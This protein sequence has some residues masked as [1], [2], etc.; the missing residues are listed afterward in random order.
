M[1]V[2][3][4]LLVSVRHFYTETVYQY[5]KFEVFTAVTMNGV[6]WDVT[7]CDSC[8]S[9]KNHG[10]TSQKTTFFRYLNRTAVCGNFVQS[11]EVPIILLFL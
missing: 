10:V 7:P 9:Y 5:I 8:G 3:I 4:A 11:A 1:Q 6:F 2:G